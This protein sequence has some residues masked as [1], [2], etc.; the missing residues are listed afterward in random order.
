MAGLKQHHSRGFLNKKDGMAAFEAKTDYYNKNFVY[1]SFTV[2]DCQRQI[3]L[4]FDFVD[5][6]TRAERLEKLNTLLSELKSFKKEM[7]N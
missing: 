6:K 5:A 1:G 2:T 3:N 4:D 7:F